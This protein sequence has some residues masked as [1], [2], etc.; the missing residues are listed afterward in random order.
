M[1]NDSLTKAIKYFD[2]EEFENALNIFMN[3]SEESDIAQ[4]YLGEMYHMGYGVE[5]DQK[6][7]FEWYLKS[8]E[9]GYLES[10]YIVAKAY[11]E[12]SIDTGEE[13]YKRIYLEPNYVSIGCQNRLGVEPDINKSFFWMLEAAKKGY[14]KAQESLTYYLEGTISEKNEYQ[15]KRWIEEEINKGNSR[16]KAIKGKTQSYDRRNNRLYE[17]KDLDTHHYDKAF[18]WYLLGASKHHLSFSQ[19]RLG[20]LYRKGY[21]VEKN[22]DK[23]IEWFKKAIDNNFFDS[24]VYACI[25]KLYVEKK[26][27]LEAIKWY[28]KGANQFDTESEVKLKQ[29]YDMGYDVTNKYNKKFSLLVKAKLGN[30]CAQREFIEQYVEPQLG[31]TWGFEKW[32]RFEVIEN[33]TYAQKRYIEYIVNLIN[34]ENPIDGWTLLAESGNSY[35][36]YVLA[37]IYKEIDE[38][39]YTIEKSLYWYEK[40]SLKE[41]NAQLDMGYHYAHGIL[42]N[43][44][45]LESYQRYQDVVH[46]LIEIDDV[47]LIREINYRKLKY[48]VGNS[49]A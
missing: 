21:G 40:A 22:P 11:I 49:L 33:Y 3:L 37:T 19:Y 47:H 15:L 13:D 39:S 23:A 36:Q 46:R 28:T 18:K 17:N 30:D 9:K 25:G 26:D 42:V 10:Q 34:I 6:K 1:R 31:Y 29:F 5:K 4:Y 20:H 7:A 43:T 2:G 41:I 48:N 12:F 14:V 44:D 16:V 8:A 45:Y 24:W 38:N 27:D 35:A 32:T